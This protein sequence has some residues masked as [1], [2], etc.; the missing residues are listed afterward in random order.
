MAH[1][2]PHTVSVVLFVLLGSAVLLLARSP[3]ESAN[4][5]TAALSTRQAALA[6]GEFPLLFEVN[7]GQTDSRVKFVAHA[8]DMTCFLLP[9]EAVLAFRSRSAE[10]NLPGHPFRP[11]PKE[12]STLALRIQL[13]G[14]SSDALLRGERPSRAKVNYLIGSS[15]KSWHTGIPTNASVRYQRVY[16]GTDLIYKGSQGRLEYDF[17]LDPAAQPERI[18]LNVAGANR[19]AIGE[20]GDV[21]IYTQAGIL[22]QPRPFAYQEI[23]GVRRKVAADY[24]LKGDSQIG[25]HIGAYDRRQPLVIDPTIEYSTLLGSSSL[26]TAGNASLAVDGA[27]N[28]Y[29]T[30]S[31]QSANFPT[32]AGVVQTSLA[33]SIDTFVTKL[34]ASGSDL[35]YSTYLGG[36]GTEY[37]DG[38]ALDAVGEAY[39][40][41][42]TDSTNFPVTPGA[43]QT[44]LRGKVN[45]FVSK[46][47]S[48]GSA[49]LYST[50]LGGTDWDF[51]SGIALD[52]DNNAY[53]T[54]GTRSVDFPV[55]AG[56]VQTRFGGGLWDVFVSKL[57]PDGRSLVYSTYLGGDGGNQ[58]AFGDVGWAIAVDAS[59]SAYVTGDGTPNFP[60]TPGAFQTTC[61]GGVLNAFVSKINP[62]GSSLVYSTYVGGSSSFDWG[63]A[64][65]VDAEGNAY[66]GGNANSSDFPITAGAFQK[67]YRG[68]TDGVVFRLN[69]TGS[70]LQYSTFLGGSAYEVIQSIALDKAGDAYVTGITYSSDFPSTGDA[71]Q[72]INR[73]AGDAFI[74]EL[75]PQ[76]SALIYSSY[77]GGGN[78]DWGFGIA[79]DP[80]GGVYISGVTYSQNFPTTPSAFKTVSD[81]TLQTFV[82]KFALHPLD[83][84][85]PLINV[86]VRPAT[87]WP[88]NGGMV[89]VTVS[90]RITDADSGVDPR[91]VRYSVRDEYGSVQPTG[92]ITLRTGGAYSF[93]VLLQA[94]R[95]GADMDGRQYKIS[96]SAS[97]NAGNGATKAASVTVAHDQRK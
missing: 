65:K 94:S 36:S 42:Q 60:I 88:P 51:G 23:G 3:F 76:G 92:T 78:M 67:S 79:L 95:R 74:T 30:G 31:T 59:R 58:Q 86:L 56:S 85:P 61:K 96:V 14:V 68:G 5:G 27:G 40:I 29:V 2:T 97:D 89:R 49:L 77:F 6:Y 13:L 21:L 1:H 26:G 22:R 55:T 63:D 43:F 9:G 11:N 90:G 52:S 62:A 44:S 12:E 54:G 66:V 93:T 83:T 41:G 15:P 47:N 39:I 35:I 33:G 50:Y 82:A 84:T 53:V 20:L 37:G 81:G 7:Q 19:L 16:P 25:F 34:N 64:I 70:A 8:K 10:T 17:V 69:P 75:N 45:A 80:V 38:I 46:L 32:T 48:D 57:S 4:S 18:A 28:A 72:P 73:G 71:L 24:V 91:S 87:L